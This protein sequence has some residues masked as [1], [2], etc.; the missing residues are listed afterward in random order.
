MGSGS[1]NK[2]KPNLFSGLR[3]S[4]R[5]RY[6]PPHGPTAPCD[7][8]A[9]FSLLT[10]WMASC[11]IF[12]ND[13]VFTQAVVVQ[14]LSV[15]ENLVYHSCPASSR[16]LLLCHHG[17]PVYLSIVYDHPPRSRGTGYLY[18]RF[19]CSMRTGVYCQGWASRVLIDICH[20]ISSSGYNYL[21]VDD[22]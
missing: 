13:A 9:V 10:T 7:A 20:P 22:G 14:C 21:V 18:V 6:D 11:S 1:C 15:T 8:L 5:R 2:R 16:Y 12:T 17:P 19:K 3:P 4:L